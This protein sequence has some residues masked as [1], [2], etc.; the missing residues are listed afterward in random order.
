MRNIR[1]KVIR[2]IIG[3]NRTISKS[4]RKHVSNLPGKYEIKELQKKPYWALHI[5]FGKY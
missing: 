4:L 5:H 2:V 1:T 3:A